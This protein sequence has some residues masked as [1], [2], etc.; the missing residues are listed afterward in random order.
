[1]K[2]IPIMYKGEALSVL[3]DDED[4]D[5]LRGFRWFFGKGK[6]KNAKGRIMRNG[7]YDPS[8]HVTVYLHREV[9]GAASGQFVDHIDRN[10][11]NNQK[12]NLRFCSQT[13]N[14]R[15]V[16][17]TANKTSRFKGVSW[18]KARAKWKAEITANLRHIFL[19]RYTTEEAA[20]KAYDQSAC[21]YF[22]QFAFLNFPAD[23]TAV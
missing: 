22:G 20:A 16:G 4:Y 12:S 21:K 11:L 5:H 15:N 8:K 7:T 23:E 17:N 13:E 6:T 14:N 9:M 3:V 1:M 19:G 10:P 2:I 18:D